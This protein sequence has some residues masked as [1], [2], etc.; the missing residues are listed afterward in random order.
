MFQVGEL[1]GHEDRI[2]HIS[3]SPDQQTVVSAAADETLRFWRC[4]PLAEGARTSHNGSYLNTSNQ[5]GEECATPDFNMLRYIRWRKKDTHTHTQ[6][7]SGDP[8]AC[9]Q[10]SPST[11]TYDKG[12]VNLHSLFLPNMYCNQEETITV[13]T[14]H[15]HNPP[16]FFFFY[17]LFNVIQVDHDNIDYL[18]LNDYCYYHPHTKLSTLKSLY[19][20]WLLI[21]NLCSISIVIN[22]LLELTLNQ[23]I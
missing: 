20:F 21:K 17:F 3:L 2:L 6:Q 8:H 22:I 16:P 18:S 5:M 10:L 4:F 23:W 12:G 7:Q 9:I 13:K 1:L 15:T 19:T 14:T 11:Q